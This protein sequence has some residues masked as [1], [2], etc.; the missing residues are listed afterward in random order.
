M[1]IKDAL[2]G[3]LGN[4]DINDLF[5]NSKIKEI[6]NLKSEDSESD[7]YLEDDDDDYYYN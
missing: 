2:E 6:F 7:I 3:Y 5:Q 4:V 1:D